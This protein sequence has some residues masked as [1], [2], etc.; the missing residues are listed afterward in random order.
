MSSTLQNSYCSGSVLTGAASGLAFFEA[1]GVVSA[2]GGDERRPGPAEGSLSAF[3]SLCG[4]GGPCCEMRRLLGEVGFGCC[5][6]AEGE[7]FDDE[8]GIDDVK[9][10]RS[11]DR[12]EEAAPADD[13]TSVSGAVDSGVG[14]KTEDVDAAS[15]CTPGVDL[16]TCVVGS[17][18]CD[19]LLSSVP[20]W[21]TPSSVPDFIGFG[22]G[23]E[24]SS[25]GENCFDSDG[26]D[27]DV[28]DTCGRR[29]WYC[30]IFPSSKDLIFE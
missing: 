23:V 11:L 4:E 10:G 3:A 15:T 6:W 16:L 7:A 12:E 18:K 2:I 24:D 30:K 22:P 25:H 14:A 27:E 5:D 21:L 9:T 13:G 19:V 17:L 28:S 26:K 8:S 1:P 20:A 29:C